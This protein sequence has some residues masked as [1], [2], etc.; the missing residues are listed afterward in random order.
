MM[1]ARFWTKLDA[2]LAIYALVN[3]GLIVA[4]VRYH[5]LNRAEPDEDE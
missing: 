2:G 5:W 4:V 3:G 1:L